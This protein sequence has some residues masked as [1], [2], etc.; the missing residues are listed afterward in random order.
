MLI[1]IDIGNTNT[2]LGFFKGKRLISTREISTIKNINEKKL[3]HNLKRT[4]FPSK[5]ISGVIISSVVPEIEKVFKRVIKKVYKVDPIFV[6]YRN[7]GLKIPYSRPWRIGADRL[8]AVVAAREKFGKPCIVVDFGTATTFDYIDKKGFYRAGPIV[9]GMALLG[10]G[11]SDSASRLPDFKIKRSRRIF[12]RS[13]VES[14]QAG[15]YEGYIG[16]TTHILKRMCGFLKRR[17][18]IIA[19]GGN[20]K[21]ICKDIPMIDKCE[22]SLIMEGLRIIFM[23]QILLRERGR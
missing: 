20:S 17:P 10:K 19:T 11:L 16:L 5:D 4:G 13:T 1:T 3:L 15:I 14:M 6:D 12:P 21:I 7:A 2:E 22:P 8:V 23:E 9:P 18:R